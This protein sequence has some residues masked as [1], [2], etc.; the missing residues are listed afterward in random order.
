MREKRRV[1]RSWI[2]VNVAVDTQTKEILFIKVTNET[3]TEDKS[4]IPLID[5]TGKTKPKNVF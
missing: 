4:C 5:S 1:H 2:K 3:L